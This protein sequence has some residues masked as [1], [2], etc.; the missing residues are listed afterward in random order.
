MSPPIVEFSELIIHGEFKKVNLDGIGP[1]CGS[2]TLYLRDGTWAK[3][4]N[5]TVKVRK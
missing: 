3:V 5:L 4:I 2:L 1:G